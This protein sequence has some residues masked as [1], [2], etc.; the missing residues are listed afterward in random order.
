MGTPA[1]ALVGWVTKASWVGGPTTVNVTA[2][3]PEAPVSPAVPPPPFTDPVAPLLFV[4]WVDWA[5]QFAPVAVTL[6]NDGLP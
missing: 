6:E 1:V 5:P 3:D 4:H 2:K